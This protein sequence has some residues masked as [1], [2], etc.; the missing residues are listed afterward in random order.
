[1]L[2]HVRGRPRPPPGPQGAA[3][4]GGHH[5]RALARA[6][7]QAGG[8]GV[9]RLLPRGPRLRL[10]RVR[11]REAR[12]LHLPRRGQ[13]GRRRARGVRH[14]GRCAGVRHARKGRGLPDHPLLRGPQRARRLQGRAPARRHRAGLRRRAP[15]AGRVS[16]RFLLLA[17]RMTSASPSAPISTELPG[18]TP[19]RARSSGGSV[20]EALV[21][22]VPIFRSTAFSTPKRPSSWASVSTRAR[23][24]ARIF[25]SPSRGHRPPRTGSVPRGK[26]TA[27]M[28][29]AMTTGS[30][31]RLQRRP[32]AGAGDCPDVI[33]FL[34]FQVADDHVA[35]AEAPPGGAAEAGA[36]EQVRRGK[37]A[38]H[39]LH[40]DGRPLVVHGPHRV[41]G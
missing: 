33:L 28:A 14:G 24:S 35:G 11:R 38:R 15:P 27:T 4:A 32:L 22:V 19:R 29:S 41:L 6:T 20:T 31:W 39:L 8:A 3:R 12:P 37:R 1:A 34:G 30:S 2:V 36:L 13:G 7:P 26:W 40:A 9:P 5:Q 21:P 23:S 25:S 10:G 17:L 18:F 16:Y